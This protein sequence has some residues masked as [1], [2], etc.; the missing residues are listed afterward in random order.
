M[1]VTKICILHVMIFVSYLNLSFLSI[2]CSIS[3]N[4]KRDC[5]VYSDWTFIDQNEKLLHDQTS[6]IAIQL[7]EFNEWYS[8]DNQI[9]NCSCTFF[10]NDA[11]I[12]YSWTIWFTVRFR[13]E[14]FVFLNDVWI[15]FFSRQDFFLFF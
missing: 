13:D 2:V 3:K 11:W 1:C 12:K 15:E 4:V 10:I 7:C 14:L 8:I 5:A 9:R 6:L